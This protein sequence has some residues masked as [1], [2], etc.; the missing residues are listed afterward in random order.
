M[1]NERTGPG[2][3][4]AQ[5]LRLRAFPVALGDYV[6]CKNLNLYLCKFYEDLYLQYFH[7]FVFA[8]YGFRLF[9]QSIGHP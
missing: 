8:M 3:G 9:Q 5:G 1:K 2:W 4:Q 7:V 6:K